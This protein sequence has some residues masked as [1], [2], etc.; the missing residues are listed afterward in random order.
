MR[1]KKEK[2]SYK[3]AWERLKKKGMKRKKGKLADKKQ[4]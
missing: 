4:K 3:T 2:W 1:W